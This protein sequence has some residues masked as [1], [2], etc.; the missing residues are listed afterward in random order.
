MAKPTLPID[1]V[2]AK[3][4]LK[5]KADCGNAIAELAW[6]AAFEA[7]VNAEA[8]ERIAQ[9]RAEAQAE[10]VVDVGK[11]QQTFAERAKVLTEALHAYAKEH[12]GDLLT[13]KSKTW[14]CTHGAIGFRAGSRSVKVEQ[15]DEALAKLLGGAEHVTA[16]LAGLEKKLAAHK[17]S[18]RCSAADVVDCS[19]A[20]SKS[21]VGTAAKDGRLTDDDLAKYGLEIVEGE[22]AVSVTVDASSVRS[23]A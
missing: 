14:K 18:E 6:M 20:V 23:E 21:K 5:S 13:G 22:E 1:R 10:L 19:I 3:A 8:N 16:L 15:P 2:G 9:V 12:R 11:G 4:L 17:I 7:Y